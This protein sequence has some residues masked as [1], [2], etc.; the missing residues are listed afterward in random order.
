MQIKIISDQVN[1][2]SNDAIARYNSKEPDGRFYD[3][4]DTPAVETKVNKF[5]KTHDVINVVPSIAI[6][7]NNPPSP[8]MIYTIIYNEKKKTA[9]EKK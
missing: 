1:Y 2:H 4:N 9:T 7:G 5:C 6:V 8:V 3:F